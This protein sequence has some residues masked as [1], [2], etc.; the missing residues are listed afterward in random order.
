MSRLR[1]SLASLA[2]ATRALLA[3]AL[4]VGRAGLAAASLGLIDL[5]TS[6]RG[7][8]VLALLA[9]GGV[10]A[11][12]AWR[13]PLRTVE[14]GSLGVRVNRV[15]GAVA[16]LPEG[17]ALILPLVHELRVYPLRDQ[18]YRPARSATADGAAA[19][20]S[21]EGLSIGAEVT[22]RYAL[23]PER[24]VQLA[25]RLPAGDLGP[26]LI[27]PIA[28][29]VLHRTFAK[30]SVRE[31]FA[32]KR[33]D[34]QREIEEALRAEL[35]ADGVLLRALFI[36]HVDLPAQYKAGLE[37]LLAEELATARM[38]Y[39]L[40]LKEKKVKEIAL[41]AQAAKV[42]RETAAEA[43]GQEEIIAARARAEAMKHVLPLKE[44]EIEQRRLEAEAR[45]VMRMKDAEA[46]AEARRLE[47]AGES[48]GRRKLAEAEAFRVE[49]VGRATSEQLAREG[50]LIS[51]NPLLIQKTLVDKLSDKIQV[52]IA[53]PAAGGFFAQG[54]LGGG[55]GQR[56]GARGDVPGHRDGRGAEAHDGEAGDDEAGEPSATAHAGVRR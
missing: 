48:D 10:G 25:R 54:L 42:Q 22:I 37:G 30:R 6:V 35:R 56:S 13:P 19:F 29:G 16:A 36:G 46:S 50:A 44:K 49:A 34:V 31:I 15:T 52:V 17:P 18:L 53:P 24:V 40:E 3:R 23:D 2:A 9:L 32:D 5:F 7:R 45:K 21:V 12:L 41:E 26:A 47:A 27:E 33:A 28:D 1:A 38:K 11:L 55:A 51:R 14:A 8:R 43:A 4:V 39:T 20:Q